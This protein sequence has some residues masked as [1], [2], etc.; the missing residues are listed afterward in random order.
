[1]SRTMPGECSTIVCLKASQPTR[2]PWRAQTA[3]YCTVLLYCC[4]RDFL[5]SACPTVPPGAP[6]ALTRENKRTCLL[7]TRRAT[8]IVTIALAAPLKENPSAC[9][10][11]V[12]PPPHPRAVT[13]YHLTVNTMTLYCV[14]RNRVKGR[15]GG[16]GSRLIGWLVGCYHWRGFFPVCWRHAMIL[17]LVLS[18]RTNRV[19]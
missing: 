17:F 3:N 6:S 15:G 7:S 14:V 9:T 16:G 18:A 13:Y 10:M 4:C 1:M 5:F 19:S 8:V 12:V 11:S 2:A